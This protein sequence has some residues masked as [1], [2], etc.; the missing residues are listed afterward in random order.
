MTELTFPFSTQTLIDL[1]GGQEEAIEYLNQAIDEGTIP[2]PFHSY[3]I[4]APEVMF[5]RLKKYP[6]QPRRDRYQ[7]KSYFPRPKQGGKMY[8]P[9]F[10][11][12]ERQRPGSLYFVS[13]DDDY[14]QID[15][16]SDHYLEDKR[17][18][19]YREGFPSVID[20]WTNP[21]LRR[22]VLEKLFDPKTNPSQ[23]IDLPIL[24]DLLFH[25]TFESKP[26]RPTWAKSIIQTLFPPSRGPRGDVPPP[27]R[28]PR[29]DVPPPS[30]GPNKENLKIIDIS[31]GWGDRLLAAMAT[32]SEY[33]AADPNLELKE[34]HDQMI[35]AFGDP[36]KQRIIYQPFEEIP[37]K[38]L[39]KFAPQGYDLVLTSPPF[40]NIELYPGPAE[41]QSTNRFPS[42]TTWLNGFLF[43]SIEKAWNLLRPG[44]Y[45]AI[46][47]GDTKNVVIAEPM[48]LFIEENL[49][50][51]SYQG[52]I[53]LS[54]KAAE[55]RPVWIWK[56][57]TGP[58]NQWNPQVQR[59]LLTA[60][61]ELFEPSNP[62]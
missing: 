10:Y 53:G 34:G 13:T 6:Y 24:R 62:F 25:A 19:T 1:I 27:S 32:N 40:F 54:G 42:V 41:G 51:A 47:L 44:G 23:Q 60:Y 14:N 61:P 43:P 46:H 16:L 18:Q 15:L 7:L 45:L 30:R 57:S 33:T 28:G 55:A 35:A 59:S 36:E 26:F 20:Y 11:Y 38:E 5:D 52:I 3:F 56:K 21:K 37:E 31:A 17:L 50:Q 12:Q 2:F 39:R 49:P 29:G 22:T 8:L 58:V 9:P 48:N 4:D